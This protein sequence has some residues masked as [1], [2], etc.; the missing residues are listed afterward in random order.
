MTP[1]PSIG[2]LIGG[3]SETEIE[4]LSLTFKFS[5]A[6]IPWT[7]TYSC[8]EVKTTSDAYPGLITSGGSPVML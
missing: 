1:K 4:T 2:S 8:S 3:G 5:G 7:P 6:V